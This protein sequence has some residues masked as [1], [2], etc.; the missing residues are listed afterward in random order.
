MATV[1]GP[2]A[3]GED[4][5]FVDSCDLLFCT[6]TTWQRLAEALNGNKSLNA[7]KNLGL[8]FY[9]LHAREGSVGFRAR[10]V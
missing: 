3:L 6:I 5:S 10:G 7:V 4:I 9:T 8:D 2:K 1:Y